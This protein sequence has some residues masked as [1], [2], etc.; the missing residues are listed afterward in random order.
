MLAKISQISCREFATMYRLASRLVPSVSR[1]LLRTSAAA[2]TVPASQRSY[3]K[4]VRF[5]AEARHQM[6]LGVDILADAVA[7]T[8][9][10]KAII[11]FFFIRFCVEA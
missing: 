2:T 11:E 5:G 6:L 10:P 7:V 4:E 9:G 1:H 8:M 3:A